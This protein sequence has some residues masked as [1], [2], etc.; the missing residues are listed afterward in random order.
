MKIKLFFSPE[1]SATSLFDEE[2]YNREYEDFPLSAE[3]VKQLEEFDDSIWEYA[4]AS[5]TKQR[6]REIYE[7]GLRLYNLVCVELGDEYEIIESLDWIK[8]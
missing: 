4:E 1:Y 6:K 3:L 7:N 2:G 8:P 5:I